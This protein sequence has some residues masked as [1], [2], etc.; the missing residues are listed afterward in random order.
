MKFGV[1]VEVDEWCTT[2]SCG[3][4]QGEGHAALKVRNSSIFKIC[5]LR[6]IQ[7]ELENDR[8]FLN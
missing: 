8:W 1:Y 6:H 3:P 5:L 2:V 7:R 4:I